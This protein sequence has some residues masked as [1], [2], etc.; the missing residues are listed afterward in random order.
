VLQRPRVRYARSLQK[1]PKICS[2]GSLAAMIEKA[3]ARSH[4]PRTRLRALRAIPEDIVSRVEGQREAR[5]SRGQRVL[6]EPSLTLPASPRR[7]TLP[8]RNALSLRRVREGSP[9]APTDTTA[10][11]AAPAGQTPRGGPAE[12]SA[13]P[14][15]G[16]CVVTCD[17]VRLGR[18]QNIHDED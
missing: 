18:G 4:C 16:L 5:A 6:R 14:P 9:S 11:P 8:L 15:R 10:A 2:A 17:A 13:G 7:T 3:I 12:V 1:V